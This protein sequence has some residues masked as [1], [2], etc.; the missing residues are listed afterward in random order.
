MGSMRGGSGAREVGIMGGLTCGS[1]V[2]H[3]ASGR[4]RP[5]VPGNLD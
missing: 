5:A 1:S 2:Q 3:P 4:Y